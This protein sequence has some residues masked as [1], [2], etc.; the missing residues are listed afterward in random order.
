M[1]QNLEH[2]SPSAQNYIKAVGLM[3]YAYVCK[4]YGTV[5]VSTYT[6]T[7]TH[8]HTHVFSILWFLWLHALRDRIVIG[9][10]TKYLFCAPSTVSILNHA[11]VHLTHMVTTLPFGI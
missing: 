4:V 1:K 11:C 10:Y 3:R 5:V 9:L 8:T 2:F 6:H 7:H